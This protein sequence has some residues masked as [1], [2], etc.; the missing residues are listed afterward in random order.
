VPS[1][2]MG[3]VF[4]ATF[5]YAGPVQTFLRET[6]GRG[7]GLPQIRSLGGAIIVLILV[8]YPYVYLLARAAFREQGANTLEAARV[9]GLNRW[10]AFWRVVLPLARPS[11]VAGVS[12]A[13][14]EAITDFGTV[15]FFSV[16]TISVGIVQ[17]WEGQQN[18]PAAIELA[19]LLMVFAL[20]LILLERALR[21]QAR[22]TQQNSLGQALRLPP[23]LPLESWQG[24]VAC[25]LC[26]LVLG[27][28]FV[29]PT[30]QLLAWTFAEVQTNFTWREVFWG[31]IVNSFTLAA[32]AAL[33]TVVIALVLAQGAQQHWLLRAAARLTTM[34]YAMPGAVIAVGVLLVLVPM[35]RWL[36]GVAGQWDI[37]IG[38]LLTGSIT[39]LTYAYV[40]RFMS[41]AYNS[42]NAS[43]IKVKPSM[44][45]A[46][47]SLGASPRRILWRIH[48]PL[49]SNGLLVGA[50]LVFVDVMKELP[51]T[52]LLRPFGM[53]TLA[54]WS[55]MQAV[56]S[57]WQAAAMPSLA[58]VLVGLIPVVILMRDPN[59]PQA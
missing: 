59:Q 4:M 2:V 42:V 19:G 38:L 8:L 23:R 47:R 22:Y 56:E 31:Y 16:P 26:A 14:M 33:I 50:L 54:I 18:L 28:A 29:L 44:E 48:A 13:L 10:R 1:F 25:G 49:V 57:F 46:A 40:V 43:L 55:Y 52:L 27:I 30:A 9:M 11:L 36:N 34:G 53:D 12:L 5:D 39:G 32:V 45:H 3:F 6:F 41:V 17:L 37:R 58:I 24:W 15:R 51:A 35:D 7:V 20:G 21:G